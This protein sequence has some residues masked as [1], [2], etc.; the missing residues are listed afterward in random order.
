MSA[1]S[2]EGVSSNAGLSVAVVGGALVIN[3][4]ASQTVNVYAADGKN[5]WSAA[6][7]A[8]QS[9]TVSLPKGVYIVNGKKVII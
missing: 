6:L 2:I 5:V 8:G 9:A 3:S 1:T 4:E 7:N